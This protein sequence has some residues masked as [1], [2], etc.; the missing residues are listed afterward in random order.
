MFNQVDKESWN[1]LLKALNKKV[2]MN[3]GQGVITLG[4][5][6]EN[7]KRYFGGKN[8]LTDDEVITVVNSYKLKS[9]KSIVQYIPEEH[10]Q[11]KLDIL[12]TLS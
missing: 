11:I 10:S 4:S 12:V 8:M 3:D 9:E 5:L 1:K 2:L 6:I 7:M